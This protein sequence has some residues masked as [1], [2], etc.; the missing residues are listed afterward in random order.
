[1]ALVV[2]QWRNRRPNNGQYQNRSHTWKWRLTLGLRQICVCVF[3]SRFF[4]TWTLREENV[5]WRRAHNIQPAQYVA[6]HCVFTRYCCYIVN[7]AYFTF[8]CS[9]DACRVIVSTPKYLDA[10]TFDDKYIRKLKKKKLCVHTQTPY[11]T[12]SKEKNNQHTHKKVRRRSRSRREKTSNSSF[13]VVV[14]LSVRF[15]CLVRLLFIVWC[16]WTL[17]VVMFFP[18][19]FIRSVLSLLIFYASPLSLS[20]TLA[21]DV[22]VYA[23]IYWY[24]ATIELTTKMRAMCMHHHSFV[25]HFKVISVGVLFILLMRNREKESDTNR[26]DFI[27]AKVN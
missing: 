12:W 10:A 13:F 26:F 14:C 24:V 1:M 16:I 15:L 27:Y 21:L 8:I 20:L 19:L 6:L 3:F 5:A 9:F 11:K 18:S 2:S 7:V 17:V 25:S 4:A 23:S 22:C